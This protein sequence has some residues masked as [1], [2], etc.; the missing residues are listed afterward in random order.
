MR[1]W[2]IGR[3]GLLGQSVEAQCHSLGHLY[4]PKEAF[5]WKVTLQIYQQLK[6][7]CHEFFHLSQN[8]PWVIFWCAGRG[9]LASTDAQMEIE[10]QTFTSF[11]GHIESTCPPESRRLGTLFYA[12]SAGGIYAGSKD[13]PLTEQT[14]PAPL[15]P[16]GKSKLYQEN[17]LRNFSHRLEIRYLIGRI[18]NIYGTRQ[19][20]KKN[21]GLISAICYSV[22]KRQPLNIFVPL[23]TSR[24]YIFVCDA[25]RIIVKT[26]HRVSSSEESEN[27]AI[28]LIVADENLTIGSILSTAKAIL[29]VN[30]LITLSAPQTNFVQPRSLHFKSLVQTDI[31]LEPKTRFSVGIKN[32]MASLHATFLTEGW[33]SL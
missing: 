2:V 8:E 17:R 32:V 18:S 15:T 31:D 13:F 1:I 33:K 30:P 29:H 23:E 10:N 16:Y 4:Q 9:T 26:V 14:K 19:D 20:L 12:S 7:S 22:L 6:A 25:A 11:L 21:Q 28:K 24:N 27:A 5:N 3:G